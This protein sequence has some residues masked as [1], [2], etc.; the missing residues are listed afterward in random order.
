M[1]EAVLLLLLGFGGFSVFLAVGYNWI[2]RHVF[3]DVSNLDTSFDA[4]GRVSMSLTAV[5]VGVQLLWPADLLQ[6]ATV[7]S[8]VCVCG[9]GGG[10]EG[11]GGCAATVACRPATRGDR[12]LQGVCVWE[13]GG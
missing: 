4:G 13:G 11:G 5:T 2:R 1:Y 6:G 8:K 7:T 9:K 12:H 10:D 3:R